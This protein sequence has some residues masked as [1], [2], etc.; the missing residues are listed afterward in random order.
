MSSLD[1]E[2]LMS[3]MD[4][5]AASVN[6]AKNK[7]A[8]EK[9]RQEDYNAKLM[10]VLEPLGAEVAKKP[11]E[12]I[13]RS[14]VK[15]GVRKLIGQAK[16]TGQRAASRA[17]SAARERLQDTSERVIA[18]A[19]ERLPLPGGRLPE[20]PTRAIRPAAIDEAGDFLQ[21]LDDSPLTLANR[22]PDPE[23]EDSPISLQTPS[24]IEQISIRPPT[25]ASQAGQTIEEG[26]EGEAPSVSLRPAA[27]TAAR[28]GEES[29]E[30][31]GEIV[32]AGG[33]PEDPIGDIIAIGA[34]IGTLLG[35]LFG[36]DH[37]PV[38]MPP[39]V[40]PSSQFGI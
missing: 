33:G 21:G 37:A 16:E 17:I 29:L 3:A 18:A 7:V 39:V 28:V 23:D 19:R 34:G 15:K 38:K 24:T 5:Y 12:E 6:A 30:E 22:F 14:S 1:N 4:T 26:A 11:L 36:G 8:E 2:R 40:N 32:A 10:G 20:L 25:G 35:G 9:A 27:R 13:V 31:T